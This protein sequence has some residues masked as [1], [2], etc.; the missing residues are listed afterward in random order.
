[1]KT[2]KLM[3]LVAL[4]CCGS[5]NMLAITQS[6]IQSLKAQANALLILQKNGQIN[7]ARIQ[8]KQ[9]QEMI[10]QIVLDDSENLTDAQMRE[11]IKI[12]ALTADIL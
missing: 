6:D 3:A 10:T 4:V 7:L 2:L 5:N 9:L 12:Q 1:M 8:A 11:L